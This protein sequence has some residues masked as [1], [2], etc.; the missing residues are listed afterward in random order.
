[1]G[2]PITPKNYQDTETKIDSNLSKTQPQETVSDIM[3]QIDLK[4]TK[5]E[6]DHFKHTGNQAREIME[7]QKL[8]NQ[9]KSFHS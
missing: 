4:L 5:L 2:A 8:F 7:V 1:M 9:L 3:K 6:E